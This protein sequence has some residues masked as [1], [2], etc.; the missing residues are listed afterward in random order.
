MKI[1][2]IQTHREKY[3]VLNVNIRTK[4]SFKMNELD[5][6]FKTLWKKQRNPKN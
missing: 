2:H 5:I 4:E 1:L 6:Q 3:T